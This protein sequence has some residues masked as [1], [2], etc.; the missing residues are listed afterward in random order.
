ML[1]PVYTVPFPQLQ[2]FLAVARAR[3]FSGAAR[4]LGVSRSAVSQSVR[5]LEKTFA[6]PSLLVRLAAS[7]S[8]KREG[9]SW[10]LRARPSHR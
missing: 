8:R 1:N 4:E 6:W 3:S 10:R 2:S 5:Q 9:A 7:H